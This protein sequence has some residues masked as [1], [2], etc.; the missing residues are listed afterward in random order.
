MS[1]FDDGSF[2][3][4]N[5]A[6]AQ[7]HHPPIALPHGLGLRRNATAPSSPAADGDL[8][9]RLMVL[10]WKSQSSGGRGGGSEGTALFAQYPLCLQ[11][12][13]VHEH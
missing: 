7:M 3:P 13:G 4:C 12:P 10:P 9:R 8:V 2:A 5:L 6:A 1:F 11:H